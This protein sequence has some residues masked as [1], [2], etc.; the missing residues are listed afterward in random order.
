MK[1]TSTQGPGGIDKGHMRAVPLSCAKSP[2]TGE[3]FRRIGNAKSRLIA[4]EEHLLPGRAKTSLPGC[5]RRTDRGDFLSVFC[6]PQLTCVLVSV[7]K[8]RYFLSGLYCLIWPWNGTI[9]RGRLALT[10]DPGFPRHPR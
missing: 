6:A 9:G 1:K 4:T 5:G 8:G 2:R 7:T 10:L 3:M